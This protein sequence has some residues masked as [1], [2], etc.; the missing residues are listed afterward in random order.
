MGIQEI[1]CDK[2]RMQSMGRKQGKGGKYWLWVRK[3][4]EFR[5]IRI[6]VAEKK[7]RV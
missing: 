1:E 2:I 3:E 4:R 6:K 7:N 5:R